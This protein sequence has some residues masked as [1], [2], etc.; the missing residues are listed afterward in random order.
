MCMAETSTI[1]SRTP[2]F[3]TIAATCGVMWTYSRCFLVIDDVANRRFPFAGERMRAEVAAQ[4]L[5]RY[6]RRLQSGSG[7]AVLAG[8]LEAL[9]RF[10]QPQRAGGRVAGAIEQARAF[11]V[12]LR[13]LLFG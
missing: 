10:K 11:A 4:Q 3:L 7:G 8:A 12:G 2:L 1:P 6:L 5:P 9:E 13:L